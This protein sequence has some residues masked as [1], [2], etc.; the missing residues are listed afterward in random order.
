MSSQALPQDGPEWAF[1]CPYPDVPGKP[2]GVHYKDAFTA[3]DYF[4]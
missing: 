3:Y 1:E 4:R 2:H